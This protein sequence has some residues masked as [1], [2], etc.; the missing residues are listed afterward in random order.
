MGKAVSR[1]TP[2]NKCIDSS[3]DYMVHL[4]GLWENPRWREGLMPYTLSLGT[5]SNTSPMYILA[6][7][8]SQ[9]SSRQPVCN[10]SRHAHQVCNYN[11]GIQFT[12]SFANATSGNPHTKFCNMQP[13]QSTQ[14]FFNSRFLPKML[15]QIISIIKD[16]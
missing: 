11:N 15:N 16:N 6:G 4:F 13:W 3:N 14:K 7:L 5:Y 10:Y 12:S 2:L 8:I 9:S 1:A